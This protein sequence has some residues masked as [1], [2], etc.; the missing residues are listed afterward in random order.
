MFSMARM[1]SI[2]RVAS[3]CGHKDRTNLI[4]FHAKFVPLESCP[5]ARLAQVIL[6]I[7]KLELF[8]KAA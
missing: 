7:S 8:R 4:W 1:N 3:P 6:D 5:T 2:V